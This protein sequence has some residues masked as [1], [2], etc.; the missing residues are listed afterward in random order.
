MTDS[1]GGS[2]FVHGEILEVK[3]QPIAKAELLIRKP[4]AEVFEAFVDPDVITRFWFDR[5][6]GPLEADKTVQWHWE[7]LKLSAEVRVKAIEKDKRI[8][9][10]WGNGSPT[11]VEWTFTPRSDETTYLSVINR[12]FTGDGDEIVRQALDSTGGFA[13]VLAAAK[14]YLEHG[15]N[16]NIVADRC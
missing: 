14:A 15:I 8:V 4:V 11:T 12:G 10:E 6:T 2:Q 3:N 9:I 13:L 1:G 5:S 7:A 16:L